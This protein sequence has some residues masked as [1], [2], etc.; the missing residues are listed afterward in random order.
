M[1]M[2]FILN[3]EQRCVFVAAD[4]ETEAQEVSRNRRSIRCVTTKA[5]FY[6]FIVL[7][8]PC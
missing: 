1:I 6:V 3:R 7:R 8:V 5:Q 2:D 4:S